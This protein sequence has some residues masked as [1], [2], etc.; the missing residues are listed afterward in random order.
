MQKDKRKFDFGIFH[1]E[2]TDRHE[3]AGKLWLNHK[4]MDS[5]QNAK[6]FTITALM[7]FENLTAVFLSLLL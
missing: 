3:S 2:A 7:K 5:L 4:N 6:L 1:C